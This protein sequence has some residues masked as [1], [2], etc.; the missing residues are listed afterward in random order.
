M[1][2]QNIDLP[3][4]QPLCS[5]TDNELSTSTRKNSQTNNNGLSRL[6]SMIQAMTNHSG[7]T[8]QMMQETQMTNSAIATLLHNDIAEG[9]LPSELPLLNV[10]IKKLPA[11]V[12]PRVTTTANKKTSRQ[13]IL[14]STSGVNNANPSNADLQTLPSSSS[15]QYA[16][17]D[18][19]SDV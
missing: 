14:A 19:I 7:S 2:A 10:S 11:P 12:C 16:G 1:P 5:N 3:A 8:R 18:T 9:K 4:R 6:I 15:G 13:A 17:S